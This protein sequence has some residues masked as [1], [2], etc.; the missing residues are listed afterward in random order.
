MGEF[1][2]SHRVDAPV[3]V[4]DRTL[5][6]LQFVVGAKLRLGQPFFFSWAESVARGGGRGSVWIERSIQIRFTYASSARIRLNHQWTEQ[7]MASANSV[8][9][10]QLTVEPVE[11]HTTASGPLATHSGRRRPVLFSAA[12]TKDPVQDLIPSA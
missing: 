6:H 10:L 1:F 12:G 5:A 7:L 3:F 2:Y 11:Y 9:G 4:D 8:E